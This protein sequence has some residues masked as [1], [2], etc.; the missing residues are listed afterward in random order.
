M[1]DT[2]NWS[3]WSPTLTTGSGFRAPGQHRLGLGLRRARGERLEIGPRAD[4][5][6]ERHGPRGLGQ[7]GASRRFVREARA[8]GA[9]QPRAAGDRRLARALGL[10]HRREQAQVLH[11]E[12]VDLE[13]RDVA[14][15]GAR[16]LQPQALRAVGDQPLEHRRAGHRLGLIG[17][18]LEQREEPLAVHIGQVEPPRGQRRRSRALPG[19]RLP[20]SMSSPIW[21]L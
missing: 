8:G 16:A 13:Q 1:P 12:A 6:G 17:Q 18:R 2:L 5:R 15:L 21:T 10:A 19:P 14:P 3:C 20:S 9:Q 4:G 7:E 11:L